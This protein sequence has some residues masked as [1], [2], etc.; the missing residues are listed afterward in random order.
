MT[1]KYI[2][3]TFLSI[4]FTNPPRWSVDYNRPREIL[5]V[6]IETASGVT[7]M[8]YL[9]V[10]SGGLRTIQACIEELVA[11]V[12]LG[13]S[14]GSVEAI[15]QDILQATCWVGRMGVSVFARSAIDIALWDALG[16]NIAI[17]VDVNMGWRVDEAIMVTW[18]LDKYNI[19]W[20]E[21]SVVVADFAGYFRIGDALRT[22]VVGGE[23]HFTHYDLAP[24]FDNPKFPIL[25][26]DMMRAGSRKCAGSPPWHMPRVCALP[27]ICSTN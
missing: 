10:L 18:R 21:E 16:E 9:M 15:W 4:P 1:V 20:L 14:I 17:M 22:R 27:R 3:T 23:G 25:Q 24:F 2:R 12:V 13:R 6:E 8:D 26:P 5:V 7:G 11:P 19:R